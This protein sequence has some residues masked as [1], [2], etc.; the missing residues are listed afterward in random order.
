MLR[1]PRSTAAAD[2]SPGTDPRWTIGRLCRHVG[3]A[4]ASVLHYESLGLLTPRG[5]SAAGYRLY[6][7]E[8]L[9]RLLTI[10][11]LR[12]A[13]LTLTDI[14]ALLRDTPA[15]APA[16]G[17][18]PVA[19]LQRRLLGCCAEIERM[20]ERQ[21][22]LARLLALAEFRD[23]AMPRD[24]AAWVD[25]LQ[26]AGFDEP[27]MTRWHAEFEQDDPEGHARFLRAIGLS[28]D[29][30]ESVRRASREAADSPRRT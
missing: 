28:E 1:P 7:D 24:K 23:G 2:V 17:H 12:D 8:A 20:R 19:L 3:L 10:R 15:P 6:D 22:R 16:D 29:E 25:L 13:G 14:R 30:A 5:R 18:D 27:E 21:R 9:D 11:R 26:R 4:R